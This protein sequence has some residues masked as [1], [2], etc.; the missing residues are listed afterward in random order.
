MENYLNKIISLGPHCCPRMRL[1]IQKNNIDV[2]PTNFFDYLMVDFN[3]VLKIFESE[4]INSLINLDNINIYDNNS[5]NIFLELNNCFFR[6]IHDVPSTEDN[7]M[8]NP[9]VIEAIYENFIS[10]YLRRYQRL[11]DK[12]K[13]RPII[14]IFMGKIDSI[15][16]ER[17]FDSMS[18]LTSKK[19]LLISLIDGG[20]DLETI[21]R[22]KK[23][24][25]INLNEF[26]KTRDYDYEPTMDFL[27]WDLIFKEIKKINDN[28]FK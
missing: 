19:I 8:N 20:S 7:S 2:G 28:H 16:S 15:Q 1:D 27:K 3:T 11:I 22:R 17:F 14:F 4:N 26:Y 13:N 10:K 23:Y 9:K 6:S 21:I 12:I 5:H 18:K 25:I 24:Y